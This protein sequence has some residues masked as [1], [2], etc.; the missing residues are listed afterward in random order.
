[1]HA[2]HV[3]G[4]IELAA[5]FEDGNQFV[6]LRAGVRSG[7]DDPNGMKKF[8]AL[9]SGLRLHFVDQQFEAFGSELPGLRRFVFQY[10]DRESVEDGIGV[11]P[12]QH[13]GVVGRCQRGFGVVVE[14]QRCTFGQLVQTIDG[15][16]EQLGD[17]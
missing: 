14:D 1:M 10:L 11:R 7:N 2:E 5:R 13:F 8:F 12:G 4:Q 15:R 17:L 16:R 6:E 9:G 3:L